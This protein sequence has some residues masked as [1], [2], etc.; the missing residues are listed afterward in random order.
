MNRT[1][2]GVWLAAS[3]LVAVSA[4]VAEQRV[5]GPPPEHAPA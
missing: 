4:V 5:A 1:L 3:L 2:R